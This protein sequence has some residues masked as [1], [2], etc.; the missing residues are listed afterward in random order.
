M[1]FVYIATFTLTGRVSEEHVES[2]T[3]CNLCLDYDCK[4]FLEHGIIGYPTIFVY[5][6][7]TTI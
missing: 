4:Y 1:T 3:S 7:Y 5:I 2:N 6:K